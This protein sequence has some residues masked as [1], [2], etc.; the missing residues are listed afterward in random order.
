MSSQWEIFS[1]SIS[2][3]HCTFQI[4]VTVDTGGSWPDLHAS[5]SM[6]SGVGGRGHEDFTLVVIGYN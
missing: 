6:Y 5:H 1:V 3:L 2:P 4:L